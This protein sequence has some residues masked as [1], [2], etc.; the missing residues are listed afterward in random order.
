MKKYIA[1]FAAAAMLCGLCSCEDKPDVSE[2]DG[3]VTTAAVTEAETAPPYVELTE[4]DF[5]PV[6]VAYSDAAGDAPVSLKTLDLSGISFGE[7]MS[8]CKA[9]EARSST[10][11]LNNR[12]ERL[13]KEYGDTFQKLVDSPCEGFC[14]GVYFHAGKVFFKVNYDDLCGQHD[15]QLF[16]YDPETEKCEKV[17]N[18]ARNGYFEDVM[19]LG[20]SLYLAMLCDNFDNTYDMAVYRYK[21]ASS[22]C[23]ELFTREG[24]AKANSNSL[25]L[26]SVSGELLVLDSTD[27]YSDSPTYKVYSVDIN[28]GEQTEL[29]STER[30][31]SWIK[32]SENGFLIRFERQDGKCSLLEYDRA[33]GEFRETDTEPPLEYCT[34]EGIPAEVTG[35]D[36]STPITVKT[37]YYTVETELTDGSVY[38]WEDCFSVVTTDRDRRSCMY[39]YDIASRECLKMT[40]NKFDI[41][42]VEKAGDGVLIGTREGMNDPIRVYYVLPKLGIQYLITEGDML[43]SYCDGDITYVLSFDTESSDSKTWSD[44]VGYFTSER[45][46]PDKLFVIGK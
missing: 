32:E 33:S 34:C 27:R 2:P 7:E 36:F 16:C 29:L 6:K 17:L 45:K 35:G 42:F 43:E 21:I 44:M 41:S 38:V 9:E 13:Q 28:S 31:I 39:T 3:D 22:E 4:A 8:P 12:T 26:A 5:T 46:S 20:D 1:L 14:D 30:Y 19:P 25:R 24:L 10:S 18:T 15:M 23:S 37:Q 40:F 11:R